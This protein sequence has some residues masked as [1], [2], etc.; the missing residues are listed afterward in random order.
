MNFHV[1]PK[2][3]TSNN[4]ETTKLSQVHNPRLC[5]VYPNISRAWQILV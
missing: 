1:I 3:E 4:L 5:V 2:M